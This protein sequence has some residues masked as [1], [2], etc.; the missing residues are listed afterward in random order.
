MA[1]VHTFCWW[2]HT[3]VK[4]PKGFD[5]KKHKPICSVGCRDAETLFN[6]FFSDE[7]IY[8]RYDEEPKGEKT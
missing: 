8:R 1:K 2:C 4:M 7:E 3:P 5:E 6:M